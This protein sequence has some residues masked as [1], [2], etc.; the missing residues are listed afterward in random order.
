MLK[1]IY[2]D[3]VYELDQIYHDLIKQNTTHKIK[4]YDLSSFNSLHEID[5]NDSLDLFSTPNLYIIKNFTDALK[6]IQEDLLK[7]IEINI[8]ND[9][10]EIIIFN[11]SKIRSDSK[12]I[13]LFTKNNLQ[14]VTKLLP[15]KSYEILNQNIRFV[16][17]LLD[18][19][20]FNYD[21]NIPLYIAQNVSQDKFTINN[22]IM[23]LRVLNI[24]HINKVIIEKYLINTIDV[25]VFSLL[26][27]MTSKSSIYDF[28]KLVNLN[29]KEE[30]DV[31]GIFGLLARDFSKKIQ[32][33][34]EIKYVKIYRYLLD[35]DF[36][37]KTGSINAINSLYLFYMYA[38]D[39]L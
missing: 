38:Q 15:E 18:E 25:N 33:S 28:Q 27:I 11:L 30:Y 14:I 21:A 37:F 20:K 34:D 32:I 2:G 26:N 1:L 13:K 8:H 36:K 29:I 5:I 31:L 39:I 16:K 19:Y 9:R 22:E 17:I 23:K 24:E 4:I 3:D 35:L 7:F 10:I 6:T 12:L